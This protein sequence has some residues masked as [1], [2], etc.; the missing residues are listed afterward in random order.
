[1]NLHENAVKFLSA[2][3]VFV[4][5][6]DIAISRPNALEARYLSDIENGSLH[7][8][9]NFRP[10]TRDY[11]TFHIS[12]TWVCR[13]VRT[14]TT[15]STPWLCRSD[16]PASRPWTLSRVTCYGQTRNE[17]LRQANYH[18]T[19]FDPKSVKGVRICSTGNPTTK[20]TRRTAYRRCR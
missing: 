8:S 5:I 14:M 3:S 1:M 6:N 12:A 19:F 2:F 18:C 13:R 9:A 17:A 11:S 7:I 10:A 4:S 15:E 20:H 16:H